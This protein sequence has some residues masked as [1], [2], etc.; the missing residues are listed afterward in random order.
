MT[1]V[2]TGIASFARDTSFQ[3]VVS[4]ASA[5]GG[6]EQLLGQHEVQVSL[7][8]VGAQPADG[9]VLADMLGLALGAQVELRVVKDLRELR[10]L[11]IGAR[12]ILFVESPARALSRSIAEGLEASARTSLKVWADSA[13]LLLRRAQ[14]A[15]AHCLVVDATEAFAEPA[16]LAQAV[17]RWCGLQ[18]ALPAVRVATPAAVDALRDTLADHLCAQDPPCL[19]LF[20]ELHASC[21]VLAG[22]VADDGGPRPGEEG[23][24][25]E[26]YRELVKREGEL[27]LLSRQLAGLESELQSAREKFAVQVAEASATAS[28]KAR[29]DTAAAGYGADAEFL[30]TR[31]AE[32][33]A[34]LETEYCRAEQ[35]ASLVASEAR[36]SSALRTRLKQHELETRSL[37]TKHAEAEALTA[38]LHAELSDAQRELDDMRRLSGSQAQQVAGQKAA[39]ASL[40]DR[41]SAREHSVATLERQNSELGAAV[42]WYTGAMGKS[43]AVKR[44]LRLLHTQDSPPHRHLHFSLDALEIG[45]DSTPAAEVRLLN[46]HGR[47]GLATFATSKSTPFSAWQPHGREGERDFMLFVPSDPAGEQSL[48]RLGSTDW[49]RLRHIAVLVVQHLQDIETNVGWRDT[50]R[51]LLRQLQGLPIRL[52][53]DGIHIAKAPEDPRSVEIIFDNGMYGDQELAQVRLRWEPREGHLQWRRQGSVPLSAWPA[54]PDGALAEHHRLP[55]GSARDQAAWRACPA[56]DRGLVLAILDAMPGA[57]MQAPA[58]AVPAGLSCSNLVEAATQLHRRARRA[59]QGLVWRSRLR[60]LLRRAPRR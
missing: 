2:D 43:L 13:R 48:Q 33:H 7:R 58:Q 55:V 23:R 54:G 10:T 3:D 52:R 21:T 34:S 1:A 47:P 46:H 39:M 27:L 49:V 16:A 37:L 5:G 12:C 8:I 36:E 51:R 11:P 4:H 53:Y 14:V 45:G 44:S 57:V 42:A 19:R 24:A 41:L 32:L 31:I 6:G 38:R 56:A 18:V 30:L 59:E 26:R 50:A 28:A 35:Q 40:R 9:S 29:S 15:P 17:A 20:E 60:R 22:A 25:I